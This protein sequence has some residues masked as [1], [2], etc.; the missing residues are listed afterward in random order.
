MKQLIKRLKKVETNIMDFKFL[1]HR[2]IDDFFTEDVFVELCSLSTD[3]LGPTDK[4]IYSASVSLDGTIKQYQRTAHNR[5]N[6][7][8]GKLARKIHNTTHSDMMHL[9][10]ELAPEKVKLYDHS[11]IN[12]IMSGKDFNYPIHNDSRK[13]LLTIIVYVSPEKNK[14]TLLYSSESGEDR[15]EVEWKQNRAFIFSRKENGIWHSVEGDGVSNRLII[16]YNLK[17]QRLV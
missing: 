12:V 11:K 15:Y 8:D 6:L 14:G 16:S 5:R 10:E 3:H 13:K 9:L 17:T 7:L 2:I 4:E 1:E